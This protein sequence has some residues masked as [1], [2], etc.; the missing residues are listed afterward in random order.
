MNASRIIARKVN[1]PSD[2]RGYT[3]AFHWIG[4]SN[5]IIAWALKGTNGKETWYSLHQANG[6]G[7]RTNPL[8]VCPTITACKKAIIE[9]N[10]GNASAHSIYEL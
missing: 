1:M 5:S 7:E 4:C 2:P 10:I 6:Y 9:L 3:H 8:R